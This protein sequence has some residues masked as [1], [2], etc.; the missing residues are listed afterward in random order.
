MSFALDKDI[1]P[2]K[3]PDRSKDIE[4]KVKC[5]WPC[6]HKDKVLMENLGQYQSAP[7]FN[8]EPEDYLYFT[9]F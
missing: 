2:C 8:S 1:C 7:T 3:N 6:Y 4:N 5:F 9:K